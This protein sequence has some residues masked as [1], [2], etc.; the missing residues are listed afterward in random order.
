MQNYGSIIS[1][2]KGDIREGQINRI[3]Q[4]GMKELSQ[5]KC[6]KEAAL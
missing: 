3:W 1:E 4:M 6:L 5:G 2:S